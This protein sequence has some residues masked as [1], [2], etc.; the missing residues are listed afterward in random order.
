MMGYEGVTTHGIKAGAIIDQKE[1]SPNPKPNPNLTLTLTLTLIMQ[2][3]GANDTDLVRIITQRVSKPKVSTQRVSNPKG[4]ESRVTDMGFVSGSPE[5]DLQPQWST[6]LVRT[7][8]LSPKGAVLWTVD[9]QFQNEWIPCNLGD[10]M[11]HVLTPTAA[12]TG[13]MPHMH[14][15][16]FCVFQVCVPSLS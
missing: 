16:I 2:E 12:A 6:F 15:R 11:C 14:C 10:A 4:L 8:F 5:T 1:P 13:D 7:T 9:W 3:A